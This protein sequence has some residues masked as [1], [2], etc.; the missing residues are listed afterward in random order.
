MRKP[1][2]EGWI[3]MPEL[4]RILGTSVK[5]LRF[6]VDFKRLP[7]V[8]VWRYNWFR[9]EDVEAMLR[10]PER[11]RR[12][13]NW[14][15][16]QTVRKQAD[17]DGSRAGLIDVPEAARRLS[18]SG[19]MVRRWIYTGRLTTFQTNPGHSKHWLSE[20]EVEEL[21]VSVEVKREWRGKRGRRVEKRKAMVTRLRTQ[22]TLKEGGTVEVGDL[23]VWERY[24]G[25]WVTTRQV[26]WMLRVT[27]RA[28]CSLRQSGRLVG[29][30]QATL[31]FG[32][33]RWHFRKADVLALM[34]DAAYCKRRGTYDL[35]LSP[36]ARA[37]R[38]EGGRT[39]EVREWPELERLN[40]EGTGRQLVD[41]VLGDRW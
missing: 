31:V 27:Q 32:R 34:N 39:G 18:V 16:Q 36:T 13:E 2:G 20:A 26:A 21:R 37:L 30:E 41:E 22:G 10:D 5:L 19:C 6:R 17:A 24:L 25:E 35:Y 7:K 23:S 29:R 33:V 1:D 9:R 12:M 14:E 15:R 8:K 40:R 4:A 11:V 38:G 28:V 3:S